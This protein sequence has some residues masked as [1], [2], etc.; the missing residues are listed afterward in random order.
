[1]WI[2]VRDATIYSLLY[3][4][5]LLSLYLFRVVTP[6]IIWSTYN[7]NHSIWHWSYCLCYLPLSWSS[8]NCS[9]A[10]VEQLELQFRCC[11]AA[12]TAVPLSWSSWNCSST[13]VEQLELQ[14]HCRGAAGTAV[15]LLW[16]SW[17]CSSTVVEQLELQFH[18]HGAAGTAVPAATRQQ[19]V[20]ETVWPVPDAVITVMCAPDNGWSYHPKHVEWAIYRNSISCT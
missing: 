12:G 2:T 20:A 3:F 17:N 5:K 18:C 14:F 13:V 6:P 8:W 11:G 9:S 19:K 16:S 1:M 7:C 15:P 4:C 10:V